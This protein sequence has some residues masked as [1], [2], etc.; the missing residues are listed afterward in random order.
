MQEISKNNNFNI[1]E[2]MQNNI[3][4]EIDFKKD[5][6][7]LI[8]NLSG[9]DKNLQGYGYKYQNYNE[10]AKEIKNVIKNHNL[11]LCL[12]QYPTS[13][14]ENGEKEH[15]IRTTFFSKS[16][17]YEFSFDTPMFTENLQFND[18]DD[19][20]STKVTNTVYHR[21][22][23]AITYTKRHA[24]ASFLV[25]EGEMDTDADPNY[26][27]YMLNKQAS[28]NRKQEQTVVNQYQKKE[29]YYNQ[30]SNNSEQKNNTI[31]VQKRDINLEQRKANFRSYAIFREASSNIKN[32][33]ND[34]TIKDKLNIIIQ[35]IDFM[36][37][38]DPNNIDDCKKISDD[39]TKFINKNA[40][41][42]RPKFWAEII[43]DYLE[44][45][46]KLSD[47]D[48]LNNFV[49]FKQLIYGKSILKFF[50]ILKEE[51]TF[52]YIFAS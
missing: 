30:K 39:L 6:H 37:K 19:E 14:F 33:V 38:I 40:E 29:R 27:N 25:I 47:I 7:T 44:K 52:N 13:K 15:V 31:Q 8:I 24:L 18:N 10:I 1:Q 46:N 42:K 45:N 36:E 35:K 4:A 20:N 48:K 34:P 16:T 17:R 28:V 23:S 22:G 9:I 43:K 26:N 49:D 50:L 2:N 32:S 11:D 5:M 21:F 3:Q 41:L 12:W 51:E